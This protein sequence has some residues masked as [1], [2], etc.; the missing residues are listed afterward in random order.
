MFTKNK[1]L[2]IRT[3]MYDFII[4]SLFAKNLI[5]IKGKRH[6]MKDMLIKNV[7]TAIKQRANPVRMFG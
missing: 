1:T 6:Q 3:C 2:V 7:E 5:N 4:N